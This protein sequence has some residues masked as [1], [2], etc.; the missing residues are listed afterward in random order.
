MRL[1][2]LIGRQPD[3]S[4]ITRAGAPTLSQC[5]EAQVSP[6]FIIPSN[7]GPFITATCVLNGANLY[8]V[9]YT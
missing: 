1:S 3:V 5:F 6:H 2:I 4:D 7:T 8:D 9:L